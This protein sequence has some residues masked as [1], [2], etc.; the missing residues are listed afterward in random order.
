MGHVQD[1]VTYRTFFQKVHY[2]QKINYSHTDIFSLKASSY[3]ALIM[4][5]IHRKKNISLYLK[6]T[7]MSGHVQDI[8]HLPKL[9]SLS[10]VNTIY[11][12]SNTF[13]NIEVLYIKL[14]KN[15]YIVFSFEVG[16]VVITNYIWGHVQD[17]KS[18]PFS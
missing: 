1:K 10:C 9:I 4:L 12:F 7:Y 2:S 13:I 6:I 15:V 17:K 8:F 16:I 3:E 14:I 5:F 11:K 18:K